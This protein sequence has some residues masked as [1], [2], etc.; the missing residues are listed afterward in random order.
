MTLPL[1]RKLARHIE[2]DMQDR[3][4]ARVWEYVSSRRSRRWPVWAMPAAGGLVFVA[5]VL[6]LVALVVPRVRR[7]SSWAGTVIEAGENQALTL[8]DGSR[9]VL[10]PSARLRW[11]VVESDRVEATL[12]RGE[13]AFEIVHAASRTFVV[14]AG[15]FDV[16]DR[17]TAFAVVHDGDIVRVSVSSGQVEVRRASGSDPG[18]RLG[19]G[20]SWMNAPESLA[21]PSPS[22]DAGAKAPV[23]PVQRAQPDPA[24]QAIANPAPPVRAHDSVRASPGP[25]ELLEAANAARVAGRPRDAATAFDNLRRRYREDPRA[26]LAAFELGRLRLDA[27][28]DASGAVEAFDDAIARSPGAGFRED[29]EA[30]R[31]EALDLAHDPAGCALARRAYLT[32]YPGGLH[33]ASVS[34][35]CP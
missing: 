26:G 4:V 18:R 9:V 23:F 12:E 11:N 22:G 34:A 7:P 8:A 33:V 27:F 2:T 28:G 24:P 6:F 29:A 31:V 3:R 14:H 21:I 32:K 19:A 35:R 17:G 13:A 30:R 16:I 20:E 25:R 15:A 10:K 1:A 5:V